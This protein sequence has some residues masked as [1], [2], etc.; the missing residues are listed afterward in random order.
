M[1]EGR[2]CACS[3]MSIFRAGV[4]A[5][6]LVGAVDTSG[7]KLLRVER[8]SASEVIGG[9]SSRTIELEIFGFIGGDAV[10]SGRSSLAG[11]GPRAARGS[12]SSS[13]LQ[14]ELG[15]SSGAVGASST[16]D[17][18]RADQ[19]DTLE[20]TPIILPT[21]AAS[22]QE[23]L[24][25]T[26]KRN[27]HEIKV[28]IYG[29]THVLH[30][31]ENVQSFLPGRRKR[32]TYTRGQS[33]METRHP[34][35]N[36]DSW[37]E[38]QNLDE[39]SYY[40]GPRGQL[41]VR[42]RDGLVVGGMFLDGSDGFLHVQSAEMYGH[43][44]HDDGTDLAST[45]S[46]SSSSSE[47]ESEAES[48][49]VDESSN[50]TRDRTSA[51]LAHAST[52]PGVENS[53]KNAN[54]N[55]VE[56]SARGDALLMRS[57]L[58]ETSK[59]LRR[60]SSFLVEHDVQ[61]ASA[62]T[63]TMDGKAAAPAEMKAILENKARRHGNVRD[64]EPPSAFADRGPGS[65]KTAEDD[66]NADALAASALRRRVAVTRYLWGKADQKRPAPPSFLQE[67]AEQ[68]KREELRKAAIHQHTRDAV[69]D[70]FSTTSRT[71]NDFL[72]EKGGADSHEADSGAEPS[73][74][75]RN[76]HTGLSPT[77]EQQQEEPD[78]PSKAQHENRPQRSG[79]FYAREDPSQTNL[80]DKKEVSSHRTTSIQ[81]TS[82]KPALAH[83]GD[84]KVTDPDTGDEVIL[85]SIAGLHDGFGD[86][87]APST[88]SD[89]SSPEAYAK[90][91]EV[92]GAGSCYLGD[93]DMHEVRVNLVGDR[94]FTD[95]VAMGSDK[96]A[97]HLLTLTL[98]Q[99]SFVYE[100]QF[101]VRLSP[102][103][104]TVLKGDPTK[105]LDPIAGCLPGDATKTGISADPMYQKLLAIPKSGYEPQGLP[106]GSMTTHLITGCDE[107]TEMVG[108]A[109]TARY[110]QKDATGVSLWTGATTW[111]TVAHEIG[112]N[113]GAEH[114]VP[115][116]TSNVTVET[117]GGVATIN[118]GLMGYGDGRHEGVFEFFNDY[119]ETVVPNNKRMCMAFDQ[120]AKAAKGTRFGECI[121]QYHTEP[122]MKC[123]RLSYLC[124]ADA[125]CNP[126]TNKCEP[127][128][129]IKP[130]ACGGQGNVCQN[131]RTDFSLAC[132]GKWDTYWY[133]DCTS[134]QIFIIDIGEERKVD[135]LDLFGVLNDHFPR[136]WRF[137]ACPNELSAENMNCDGGEVIYDRTVEYIDSVSH[138]YYYRDWYKS[139][140]AMYSF[141]LTPSVRRWRY[142][143]LEVLD[144]APVKPSRFESGGAPYAAPELE[145]PWCPDGPEGQGHGDATP[146]SRTVTDEEAAQRDCIALTEVRFRLLQDDGDTYSLGAGTA[147]NL[148]QHNTSSGSGGHSQSVSAFE[149]GRNSSV[150]DPR[151][152]A[153]AVSAWSNWTECTDVECDSTRHRSRTHL[154]H[155]IHDVGDPNCL[156]LQLQVQRERCNEECP[157]RFVSNLVGP[158]PL[159]SEENFA[160]AANLEGVKKLL[161][162]LRGWQLSLLVASFVS[163]LAYL[164]YYCVGKG[165]ERKTALL[166]SGETGAKPDAAQHFDNG[167]TSVGADGGNNKPSKALEEDDGGTLEGTPDRVSGLPQI[168]E[169]GEQD[170][171]EGE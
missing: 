6:L 29:A 72:E 94:A 19:G 104:I 128:R 4:F 39:C 146:E 33:I 35:E 171:A 25:D 134:P 90:A 106:D 50:G 115:S 52:D 149:T 83:A 148:A 8:D 58:R 141:A 42:S 15:R 160:F 84:L 132:D 167:Q 154:P 47:S 158:K 36:R 155:A 54:K 41:A 63:E 57:D 120:M 86:P 40:R 88:I 169:S 26:E 93:D 79:A 129:I 53:G 9:T 140:G 61:W 77:Q 80:I 89:D 17:N 70:V 135:R 118:A 96:I 49:D 99:A 10:D 43:F 136:R 71:H 28:R 170:S 11:G 27:K 145:F 76:S 152:P 87:E 97:G 119:Q 116:L 161:K 151:L 103:K 2:T 85:D 48:S 95:R 73:D 68:E 113:L 105:S 123:S 16:I 143:T 21:S 102:G 23:N 78:R 125:Y 5:V 163:L 74:D 44:Q 147:A 38:K 92:Y 14:Q 66:S 24:A 64:D 60:P 98:W 150:F 159:L 137:W 75:I 20:Q 62:V 156:R 34:R 3:M 112:H 138:S 13:L 144:S 55:A 37:Q 32:R 110:C 51:A 122:G 59:S 142:F 69:R 18:A 127:G 121:Y 107:S 108:L 65:M 1:S 100:H 109:Q 81:T 153:C 162:G 56:V 111:H 126:Y 157:H 22:N 164:I 45:T 168:D 166:D 67:K 101:H 117:Y 7:Q 114:P 82:V 131:G 165:G 91:T 46:G 130:V 30:R 139:L 133:S 12:F 124:G 31:I